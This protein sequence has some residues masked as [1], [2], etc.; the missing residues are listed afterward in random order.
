MTE[1]TKQIIVYLVQSHQQP[2]VT[3]LMKLCY[4]IDLTAIKKIKYQ[5]TDFK[6]LRYNFGPFD[7][8]IYTYLENLTTDDVIKQNLDYA[9]GGADYITFEESEGSNFEISELSPEELT[10]VDDLLESLKGFGAKTL[11][12]I[13][14]KTK[15]MLALG[16]TL[17]GSEGMGEILDLSA[18]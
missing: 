17:G 3:S 18:K 16:A 4:L 5:I 8:S 13:A 11:T 10:L 7:K 6:Y 2:T 1:K 14:Y 15:P 12:A 9:V